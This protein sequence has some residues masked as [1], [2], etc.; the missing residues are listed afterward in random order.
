MEKNSFWWKIPGFP[1]MSVKLNKIKFTNDS[2]DTCD[3]VVSGDRLVKTGS[4][5]YTSSCKIFINSKEF[6]VLWKL[7]EIV[8]TI[9]K[10]SVPQH[11]DEEQEIDNNPH[12]LPFKVMGTCFSSKRQDALEKSYEILYE[13]NRQVFVKLCPE[14]ENENDPNSISVQINYDEDEPYYTVGYIARELTK[15]MHPIINELEVSVKKIRFCT[16]YMRIGFYLTIDV[17]KKRKMG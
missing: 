14:P 6:T 2:G 5:N 13:Y 11:E 4:F 10:K 12:T 7:E 16:T 17:T 8:Q 9:S 15:Y 1:V 3:G